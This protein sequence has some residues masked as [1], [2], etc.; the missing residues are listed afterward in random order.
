MNLVVVDGALRKVTGEVETPFAVVP[1]YQL[2]N[3]PVVQLPE[4]K[5]FA[6]PA[7]A[8]AAR[9]LS[10]ERVL[11]VLRDAGVDDVVVVADFV[12]FTNGRFT[13][14]FSGVGTG[15][16]QQVPP[17]CPELHTAVLQAGA[18]DGGTLLVVDVLP[19]PSVR[20]WW[21]ARGIELISTRSQPEAALCRELEMCVAVVAVPQ[22]I[23][24]GEWVTAVEEHLPVERGCSCD[25]TMQFARK[26]GRLAVDWREWIV[27]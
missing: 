10:G 18:V 12:E 11:F 3:G 22:D 15:F 20:Q 8:Y 7:I 13:T 17:F 2:P 9:A 23:E 27:V 4:A 16:V 19:L 6:P 14:F 25:Q 1:Y 26:S 5:R 24:I 21:A